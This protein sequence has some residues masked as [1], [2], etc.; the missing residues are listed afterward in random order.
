MKSS[1]GLPASRR[2]R[3]LPKTGRTHQIRLHLAHAGYPV[4]CDRLYGGRARITRGEL[5]RQA[6]DETVI[7]ERQALHARRLKLVLPTGQPMEF[8]APLP[9]DL[10]A[11]LDELRRW[12]PR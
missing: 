7:L 3:A 12:R 11:T 1:S 8:V 6:G 9:A 2:V 5:S 10:A 4:L